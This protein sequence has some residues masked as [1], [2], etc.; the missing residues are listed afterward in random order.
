MHPLKEFDQS[1][2]CIYIQDK[3]VFD[4]L[5]CLPADVMSPARIVEFYVN[6]STVQTYLYILL[7]F[8]ARFYLH[9]CNNGRERCVN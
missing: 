8:P 2:S 9:K 1:T 7:S 4:F 5:N 6:L 3:Q